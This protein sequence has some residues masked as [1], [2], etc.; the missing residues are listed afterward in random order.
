[1]RLPKLSLKKLFLSLASFALLAVLGELWARSRE[2][3]PFDLLDSNPYVSD[4]AVPAGWLHAPGFEGRWDGTWYSINSRGM[5][6]PEVEPTFG[7]EELRVV[8]LGDSCTFGKGVLESE[9]W[10]RVLESILR[11]RLADRR[12]LVANLGHNGYSGKAYERIFQSLGA[13]LE[14]QVVVVGYNLNDFPNAI[15]AVD[16]KVFQE[17]GL[18]KLLSQDVRDFMG[19]FALYRWARQQ[20]YASKR[21][22]DWRNAEAFARGAG[23]ATPEVWVEQKGYL[24]GI[25]DEAARSGGHVAVFLFP[26]E[27]QVYLD[28]YDSTPID[29]LRETCAE[30]G[31]PFFDLT[32][33]FRRRAR[34]GD[35][36]VPLFLKGDRYHPNPLGY[37]IVADRVAAALAEQGWLAREGQ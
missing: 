16:R 20:Y 3:G 23:D 30:L 32:E 26:Y 28:A 4:P 8:A 34:E 22:S 31:L 24:A 37:R 25:R 29:R 35:P 14:P 27:S 19:R 33:D 7:P 1:M 21:E 9:C 5:R 15:Q 17:R 6:G 11:A 2:P 18:R 12:V 10:P 36:P 13:P